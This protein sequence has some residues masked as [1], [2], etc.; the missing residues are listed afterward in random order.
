MEEAV[1]ALSRLRRSYA[2]LAF[3]VGA[4]A[5]LFDGLKLLVLNWRLGLVE[6]LPAM[7][8]WLAMVDLR[9]HLFGGRQLRSLQ[10]QP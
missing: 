8:A 3:L 5:M 9:V 2:P 4:F 6:A 7:W 1:V 10:G